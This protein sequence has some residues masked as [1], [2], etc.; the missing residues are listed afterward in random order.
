M[1]HGRIT[2]LADGHSYALPNDRRAYVA[3]ERYRVW[4]NNRWYGGVLEIVSLGGHI[5]LINLLDL[6]DYLCGVVPA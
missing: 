4:A 6:E 5:T 1:A 2:D 3:S